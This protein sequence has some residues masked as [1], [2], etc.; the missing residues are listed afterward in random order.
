[1][2]GKKFGSLIRFAIV[3]CGKIAGKH[4]E[5]CNRFGKL[6][7]VC[8]ID[9][10]RATAL[11]S[12]FDTKA[13]SSFDDMLAKEEE[14]TA[15]AI[16]TPNGLHAEQAIKALN[17]GLHVICEKPMAIV[18][19]DAEQMNTAAEKSGKELFVIKQN[20]FNPAV[21]KTQELLHNNI[22][23]KIYSIQLNAFWHR[24][25]EYYA[26]S[27][28]G[29][30]KLD[31]GILF[32]QFSHFID[33][34]NWLFG[35]MKRV[36]AYKRNFHHE[37]EKEIEDTVVACFEMN[38]G[39]LGTGHFSVNSYNA[40][41]E[42]SLTIIAEKGTLKIGGRYLNEI[43]YQAMDHPEIILEKEGKKENDYGF[44]QGSMSNHDKMYEHIRD[45]LTTGCPNHFSGRD[46]IRTVE[47]I[48]KIYQSTNDTGIKKN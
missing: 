17:R 32:T 41:M 19:A 21:V 10:K 18:L 33:L 42:G 34:V 43:S 35:D 16:C 5:L 38:D 37:F 8:D 48:Q 2:D 40:N 46:G 30:K 27:W 29:D 36:M 13:Y 12:Q 9:K 31:G 26:K 4:A 7:A 3:G 45:V 47:M 14:L 6:I 11:A 44:Y 39:I 20:R 25:A 23:G 1:L 28:H 24:D 15:I 22:L